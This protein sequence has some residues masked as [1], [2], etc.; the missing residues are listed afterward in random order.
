[1]KWKVEI[2]KS[3]L[4]DLRKIDSAAS[5]RIL[6]YVEDLV[7]GAANSRDNGKALLGN[8]SGIWSYR[9]LK[10]RILVEFDENLGVVRVLK[11]APRREVYRG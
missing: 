1:M 2:T 3:A 11:I 10:Y 6:S 5:S 9:V 7:L 8:L 4:K